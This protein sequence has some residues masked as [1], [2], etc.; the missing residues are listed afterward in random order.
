[1]KQVRTLILFAALACLSLTAAAQQLDMRLSCGDKRDDHGLASYFADS[2]TIRLKGNLIEEFNWESSVFRSMSGVECSIDMNDGLSA[3]FIGDEQNPAWRIR[4]NDPATARDKRG[5]DFSHGLNCTIRIERMGDKVHINP[6]CPAMC[7]SR[8]N[9]SE[10]SFDLKTG[11][12]RYE[13]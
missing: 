5:Y 13:D 10:F 12:C 11:K 7:G 6:S 2:G 4:L 1:M 8:Q 9:F 3:E